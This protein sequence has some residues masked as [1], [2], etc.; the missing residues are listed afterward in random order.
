MVKSGKRRIAILCYPGAAPGTIFS[1]RELLAAAAVVE[2]STNLAIDFVG[3]GNALQ[4][5]FDGGVT[6]KLDALSTRYDA[7]FIPPMLVRSVEEVDERIARD[8]GL[9]EEVQKLLRR[10]KIALGACSGVALLAEA[11]ILDNRKVTACWW[12]ESWFRRR[13]PEIDLDTSRMVTKSEDVWTAGAGIAYMHMA[14]ELLSHWYGTPVASAISRLML[15]DRSPG[16]QSP[17]AMPT[18]FP[19]AGDALVEDAIRRIAELVDTPLSVAALSNE[20]GVSVRTLNRRFKASLGTAPLEAIH[21]AKLTH[22]KSLLETTNDPFEAITA[23][24]GFEDPATFH[25]LFSRKVGISPSAY[26]DRFAAPRY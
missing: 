2:E 5:T 18:T 19:P 16:S 3:I 13:F 6:T 12:L 14:L 20:L 26:R 4:C 11:G 15:L 23:S 1:L 17:Y 9:T 21:Q 24:C 7:T 22:A 25:K 8:H 10:S